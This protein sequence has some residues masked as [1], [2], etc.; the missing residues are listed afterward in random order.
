MNGEGSGTL[1]TGRYYNV[2]YT[3]DDPDCPIQQAMDIALVLV[4]HDQGL[5]HAGLWVNEGPLYQSGAT[6][7]P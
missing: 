6:C 3:M 1:K 5:A 7:T 2:S 4:P